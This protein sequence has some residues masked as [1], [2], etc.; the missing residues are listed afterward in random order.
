MT[1]QKINLGDGTVAI[2][3]SRSRKAAKCQFCQEPHT[4][5]CDY[6]VA[7][8]KTC[9]A[10]LCGWHAHRVGPEK[11]YCPTHAKEAPKT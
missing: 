6:P 2:V 10:K 3:C 11:D 1:C 5:L 7:P 8:G 4:R 9:D